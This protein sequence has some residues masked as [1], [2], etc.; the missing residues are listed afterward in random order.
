MDIRNNSPKTRRLVK[1]RNALSRTLRRRY[2]H[3]TQRTIFAPSRHNKRSREEIAEIDAELIQRANRIG[4]GY[5][6]IEIEEEQ[7]ETEEIRETERAAETEED[8]VI[9][10]GDN[11]PIMD[12]TKY[13][14][15][16]N[17]AKYIQIN[18]I[19]GKLTT[20]K[21]ATEDHI[22]E[23]EFEFMMDLKSLISK[24]A[25]D[26]ELTRVRN[27]MR[28][29]DRETIPED[30]KAVFD[31]LS[32]RWTSYLPTPKSSS[33]WTSENGY[34]TYCTL[35]T[36]EAQN[37]MGSDNIIVAGHE[38]DIENTVKDCTASLASGKGIKYQVPKKHY[39]KLEK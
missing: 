18:H 5:Q 23:A 31:K 25:I 11:L 38:Q 7:E 22:K 26:P 30:Y 36:L 17:E 24:T 27:S 3:Q 37:D 6:P 34:W 1:Q 20:S 2:Y 8:S 9:M 14:T 28:R 21:K 39:G 19:V 15:D 13:N 33:R 29:E 10:L 12:L 32:I 16:G 4:G 35:V